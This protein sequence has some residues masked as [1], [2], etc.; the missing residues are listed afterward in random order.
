[1]T[2]PVIVAGALVG[3]AFH[4]RAIVWQAAIHRGDVRAMVCAHALAEVYSVLS[5]LS[6]GL[7]PAAARVLV[8]RVA[9]QMRVVTPLPES[10]LA[11]TERCASRGLKSGVVFDALHLIEAERTG[12]D[13]L[14][15]FKTSS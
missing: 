8:S 2:R 7:S 12:A 11:A 5:K 13:V 4:S 10:Y 9:R 15:T 3:H 1:M 14:L 6:G